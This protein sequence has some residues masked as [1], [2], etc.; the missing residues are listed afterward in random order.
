MYPSGGEISSLRLKIS[1][2]IC[3][4]P[5]VLLDKAVVG[6]FGAN[7][8]IVVLGVIGGIL[9]A[10]VLGPEGRGQIAAILIMATTLSWL[11]NCGLSW[12]NLYYLNKS[13]DVTATILTNSLVFALIISMPVIMVGLGAIEVLLENYSFE[14]K[15][16]ALVY[17]ATIPLSIAADYMIGA[18]QALHQFQRFN[19][20]RVGRQAIQLSIMIGLLLAH[21]FTVVTAILAVTMANVLIALLA[22]EWYWRYFWHSR[23]VNKVWLKRSLSFGLKAYFGSLA[24]T[25]NRRLDQL[26]MVML[27][28]PSALGLYSVAASVS[29]GVSIIPTSVATVISPRVAFVDI[30]AG[31]RL[32]KKNALVSG[33][34]VGVLVLVG[35]I[36]A[37]L[38]LRVLYGE[39]FVPA[40]LT[41]QILLVAAWF[42]GMGDLI[43]QGLNGLGRPV[44]GTVS[45]IIALIVT[46]AL[47]LALVPALGIA[48]AALAS[49]GAYLVRFVLLSLF[50]TSTPTR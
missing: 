17:F 44:Q 46:L 45:E 4:I 10:R 5:Y 35:I 33:V 39:E 20:M 28:S 6:T 9:M 21:S 36:G 38:V 29:E 23:K 1:R 13:P 24:Q 27:V 3:E 19:A 11:F 8:L 31:K 40:T 50:A 25:G 41:F 7:I 34:I 16:A 49:L 48:G 42:L 32:L 2:F 26:L 14:V 22:F 37:N 15:I 43:G 18:Q 12:G 30:A 47:L